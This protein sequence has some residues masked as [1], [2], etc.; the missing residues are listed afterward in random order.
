[1]RRIR[2]TPLNFL[3]AL[4]LAG[5]A[6]LWIFADE[7]GWR[8][9]GSIPVLVLLL[10]CLLSDI[11]FRFYFKEL[12]RIWIVETLFLI[13]VLLMIYILQDILT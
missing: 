2:F 4:L 11:F 3:A 12:K 8:F 9:L 10:L 7:T 6:Y 5:L 13:F 1:M